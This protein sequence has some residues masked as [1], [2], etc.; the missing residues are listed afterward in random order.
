ME[1]AKDRWGMKRWTWQ[2]RLEAA[3]AQPWACYEC[4]VVL[5]VA[6][7]PGLTLTT[8]EWRAR[9]GFSEFYYRARKRHEH[10][11]TCVFEQRFVKAVIERRVIKTR[12]GRPGALPAAITFERE[13]VRE[14]AH[15]MPDDGQDQYP[16]PVRGRYVHGEEPVPQR[17][18]RA[19]VT[20]T[21]E[22]ACLAHAAQQVRF[23][24]PLVV[25]YLPPEVCTYGAVIRRA[26]EA[27]PG[28]TRV[29]YATLRF[30]APPV[31]E[32]DLLRLQAYGRDVVV[33][34]S[35]WD[36]A[37]VRAFDAELAIC[38]DWT[39]DRWP[40]ERSKVTPRVYV[41]CECT[42]PTGPLVVTDPRKLCVAVRY[43]SKS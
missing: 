28:A 13:L 19:T 21:I 25:Q 17:G 12:A 29:W 33:D 26:E 18:D 22:R 37:V 32:G 6:Q 34:R 14:A 11:P 43:R 35:G 3:K 39:R 1:Y 23:W 31:V 24:Q 27:V 10:R 5:D 9:P 2:L 7:M 4:G 16:Q 38:V 20:S 40:K 41:L 15:V 36:P 30:A 42:D 8:A